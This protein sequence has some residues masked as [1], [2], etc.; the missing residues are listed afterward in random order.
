MQSSDTSTLDIPQA[1][2][3]LQH[4]MSGQT[5]APTVGHT[6]DTLEALYSL[7]Y[8]LY[9]QAKYEEAMGIFSFLLTA[10]HFDR[11]FFSGFAACLHMQRRYQDALKY[12]GIASTLDL[13]D[14]EPVMQSA[15]CYL[16]LGNR[17]MARMSIDYGLIQARAH[18]HHRSHVSRLEAM[19][20]FLDNEPAAQAPATSAA[21][22]AAQ[23]N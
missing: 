22:Q 7:A 5:L 1:A 6:P 15:Q 19:L 12:Y 18:A 17:A 13:T 16:A 20:A 9:S 21:A 11:R 3:L 8:N 10:N 23:T 14:P 2:A 4:M